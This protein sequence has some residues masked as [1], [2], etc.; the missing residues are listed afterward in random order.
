MR[1]AGQK[2]RRHIAGL[3]PDTP[4]GPGALSPES[5]A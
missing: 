1:L 3:R 5:S 4:S 2:T